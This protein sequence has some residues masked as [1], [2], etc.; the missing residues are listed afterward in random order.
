M[1]ACVHGNVGQAFLY[2]TVNGDGELAVQAGELGT[3]IQGAGDVR[4]ALLEGCGLQVVWRDLFVTAT[5]P[6]PSTFV[7]S[8]IMAATFGGFHLVYAIAVWALGEDCSEPAAS[9][10]EAAHV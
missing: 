5:N 4:V 7:V 10:S 2:H 8:G 1:S 3:G 9:R 6:E